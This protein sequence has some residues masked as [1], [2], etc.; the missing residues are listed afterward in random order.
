MMAKHEA[1]CHGYL[2]DPPQRSSLW[3]HGFKTPENYNDFGLNCGGI[4]HQ[5]AVHN[6]LCGVCGD[7]WGRERHHEDGGKYATGIIGRKYT[8]GSVIQTVVNITAWHRGYFEYKLCPKA[9][10]FE[11]VSQ[12]CLDQYPLTLA[13]GSTKYYPHKHGVFHVNVKLP[14]GL[15][16]P[17][18]VLQWIYT[19]SKYFSISVHCLLNNSP[20]LS[21][22]GV[23]FTFDAIIVLLS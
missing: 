20:A 12:E 22:E 11:P 1:Y 16:C 5:W 18:C 19:T 15:Y 17:H 7:P 23:Q 6:G 21:L 14:D 4:A 8:S 10:P 2:H 9:N 13:N 3:R